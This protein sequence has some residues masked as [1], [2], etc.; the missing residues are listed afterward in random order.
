MAESDEFLGIV[1]PAAA[2]LNLVIAVIGIHL[3]ARCPA[4]ARGATLNYVNVLSAGM[5]LSMA[6]IHILPETIAEQPPTI[7]KM[8]PVGTEEESA[9]GVTV[10]VFVGFS[11]VLFFDRVIFAAHGDGQDDVNSEIRDA[12]N[13]KRSFL[14]HVRESS[15]TEAGETRKDQVQLGTVRSPAIEPEQ[16]CCGGHG[17]EVEHGHGHGDEGHGHSHGGHSEEHGHGH[18]QSSSAGGHGHGHSVAGGHGHGHGGHG[19]GH[20]GGN[21]GG[22]LLMVAMSF[23]SVFEGIIIGTADTW[24]S[25]ATITLIV[26]CHKWADGFAVAN[27]ILPVGVVSKPPWHLFSIL[28]AATPLGILVGWTLGNA[29]EEFQTICNS[30]GVGALL[31]VSM[32][33]IIPEEF[34]G[35]GKQL[36]K[37]WLFLFGAFFVYVL[38]DIHISHAHGPGGGCDHGHSHGHSHGHQAADH[39]DHRR[40]LG[41]GLRSPCYDDN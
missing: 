5:F 36:R 23:H 24:Q 38:T 37:F 22:I 32:V 29:S 39:D 16:D 41:R 25:V 14:R 17:H 33:E 20:G 9:L 26:G 8:L 21:A 12:M 2:L 13:P 31:Y 35:V 30:L 19:H 4:L 27:Q 18:G 11:F 15:F 7:A 40:K 3:R 1:K 6:L 28:I 10:L 34:T